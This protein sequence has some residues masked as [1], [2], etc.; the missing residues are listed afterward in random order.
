MNYLEEVKE[1]I[2]E[3]V[4]GFL[5]LNLKNPPSPLYQGGTKNFPLDKG[6]LRGVFEISAFNELSPFMQKE[7]IRYIYFISN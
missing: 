4:K 1:N 2:D 5:S 3:E 7:V 6:G